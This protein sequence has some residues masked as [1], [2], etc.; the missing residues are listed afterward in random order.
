MA[1]EEWYVG[2]QNDAIYIIDQPPRPS[3]DEINPDRDVKVIAKVYDAEAGDTE[4][5]RR[6]NLLAAA[7]DLLAACEASLALLYRLYGPPNMCV[8]DP[9]V[10]HEVQLL[11]AAVALAKVEES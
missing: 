11:Q 4:T 3:N 6:A 8:T 9:A 5:L 2:A 10:R 1:N 7:P